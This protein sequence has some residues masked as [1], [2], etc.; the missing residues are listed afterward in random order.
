M[1]E[2][3]KWASDPV[4]RIYSPEL[5]LPSFGISVTRSEPRA[6]VGPAGRH[7]ENMT[8]DSGDAFS[9]SYFFKGGK[10]VTAD[11]DFLPLDESYLRRILIQVLDREE[12]RDI[13]AHYEGRWEEV[14]SVSESPEGWTTFLPDQRLIGEPRAQ[15]RI[16]DLRL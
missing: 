11:R 6:E 10:A 9:V 15:V 2:K 4:D 7:I 8:L 12:Y 14:E 5:R 3:K 13:V 1:P 16:T